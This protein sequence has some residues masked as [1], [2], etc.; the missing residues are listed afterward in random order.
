MLF[1][2]DYGVGRPA[3]VDPAER[4]VTPVPSAQIA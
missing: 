2:P 1:F 3:T 4:N